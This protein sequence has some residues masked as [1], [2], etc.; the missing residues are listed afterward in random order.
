MQPTDEDR[1]QPPEV[2]MKGLSLGHVRMNAL[3]VD[4]FWL[5]IQ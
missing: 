4:V 2:E 1:K 3:L 5:G